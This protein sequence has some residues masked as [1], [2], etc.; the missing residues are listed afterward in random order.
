MTSFPKTYLT[1]QK[2]A[3]IP[4]VLLVMKAM[5]YCRKTIMTSAMLIHSETFK[6]QVL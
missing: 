4:I 2:T 3:K 1:R 5:P 6:M